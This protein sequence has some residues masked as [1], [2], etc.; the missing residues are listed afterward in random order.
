MN[1]EN[2]KKD[3]KESSS[4]T[5]EL[6]VSPN[7]KVKEECKQIEEEKI[8]K[9]AIKPDDVFISPSP[10][11][12]KRIIWKQDE[13]KIFYSKIVEGLK[14]SNLNELFDNLH[15]VISFL[16]FYHNGL[17]EIKNKTLSKIRDFYYRSL[18]QVKKLLEK[19]T[20]F[21]LDNNLK[22]E[23]LIALDCYGKLF[24]N[25]ENSLVKISSFR[26]L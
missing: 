17:K 23:A 2:N 6:C 19:S 25:P 9:E 12:A 11:E 15:C 21:S 5:V 26:F 4:V 20:G 7:G 18:K 16:H 1:E 14:C 10:S 13:E 24:Q 3:N 8:G 22:D